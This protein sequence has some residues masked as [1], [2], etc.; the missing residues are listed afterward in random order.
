M[1][2]RLERRMALR[3]IARGIT[4]GIAAGLISTLPLAASL[5]FLPSSQISV[6]M[7][8]VGKTVILGTKIIEFDVKVLG[9]LRNAGPAGDL[10]LFRASGPAIQDVGGLAAGMSGSPVYLQGRVA[11]AFSY[12]FQASDPTVGLFT[13]IEDML[14]ALPSAGGADSVRAGMYTIPA[15]RIAGRTIRHIAFGSPVP[16]SASETLVAIPAATP[17]FVA[18]LGTAAQEAL[19]EIL[20]P[21]GV[22]PMP[23]SGPVNLPASLPL[24]PGSAIS[25][26]LMQGD[27]S[28]YAM[29]TL[30]YRDGDRILA[31]GHPFMDLGRASYL[32]TNATIFQTLRGNQRNIKV[33]AA[34]SVVG[35][36]S[37]DRPAA[38]GGTVG[39]L[40]RV[41]GVRVRVTDADAGISRRFA[42]QVVSNKDLAPAL[43]TLGAQA[44]VERTLDRSGA[45]TAQVR[46][47]LRGRALD[48]PIV[49]ENLFY[50][51]SDIAARAL[52]EVPQALQLAFDN[53]FADVNPT[54]MEIDVS[55]TGQRQTATITDVEMA[56][57]PVL[58]GGTLH[59][60]V[61]LRPFRGAPVT[62]DVDLVVPS[63][64]PPGPA[65]LV[66]RAGGALLQSLPVG[67]VAV[68]SQGTGAA[69][70]LL[71][72][73]T[74]FERGEKNTDLVIDLVSGA[75]RPASFGTPTKGPT[76]ASS[77]RTTPWVLH[78]RSEAPIPIA[79]G[80]H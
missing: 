22:V 16:V 64:F 45:G 24:E 9:I 20:R 30:S 57:D 56:R 78:G 61:T 37:E 67:G 77:T 35:T 42:F 58:P 29:G 62:E 13:P 46:V 31:F 72:A 7:T 74:A 1:D 51:G 6:G 34:G 21:M 27:V 49:R 25:V 54:D 40:P 60:R 63:D 39:M 52:A 2:R 47:V 80:V 23:G 73:I 3:R 36:I 38:I 43:V 48:H 17:L 71:D 44:A 8:G 59:I 76:R 65:I 10:V 68:P 41:F 55:I 12:S 28:A 79:G 75:Q 11:G 5:S 33:G 66:V 4:V 18:G 50:S 15:V 69:R 53:D 32:L 19:A 26:A 14:K 70:N